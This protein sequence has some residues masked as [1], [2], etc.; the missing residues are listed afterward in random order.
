MD[1]SSLFRRYNHVGEYDGP[2]AGSALTDL[3]T[4]AVLD[5]NEYVING[6]KRSAPCRT[7]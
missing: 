2:D 1:S 5:G 7:F 3:T 4:K 6:Q